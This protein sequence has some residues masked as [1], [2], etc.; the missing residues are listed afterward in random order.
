MRCFVLISDRS[1]SFSGDLFNTNLIWNKACV[2]ITYGSAL[3]TLTNLLK[4]NPKEC[5]MIISSYQPSENL[6]GGINC[7]TYMS[8][9]ANSFSSPVYNTIPFVK[10]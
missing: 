5:L 9:L 6:S 7:Q 8:N 1:T 2:G 3:T 4:A 10:W